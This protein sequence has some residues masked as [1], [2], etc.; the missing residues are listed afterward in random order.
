MLK[1]KKI[2][3]FQKN[4]ILNKIEIQLIL[5]MLDNLKNMKNNRWILEERFK[6]K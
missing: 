2:I 6:M 5:K 1:I 3:K 4:L